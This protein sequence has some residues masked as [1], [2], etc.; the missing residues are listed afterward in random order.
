[1][2]YLGFISALFLG[3]CAIPLFWKTIKE[4]HCKGL[5]ALFLWCWFIGEFLGSIY[6]MYLGDLPLILNYVFNTIMTA[7]ILSYKIRRG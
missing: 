5:S 7:T 2:E 3:V 4:G 6:V 1:M